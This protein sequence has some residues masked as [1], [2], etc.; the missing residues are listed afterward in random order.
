M[1]YVK[2]VYIFFRPERVK[3]MLSQRVLITD[4][5]EVGVGFEHMLT[6]LSGH[7]YGIKLRIMEIELISS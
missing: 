4:I 7:I 1:I 3:Q 2:C 5:K 6:M